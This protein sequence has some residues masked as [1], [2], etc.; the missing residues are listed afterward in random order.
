MQAF[1]F[2]LLLCGANGAGE[3][4]YLL[5]RFHHGNI[6][7]GAAIHHRSGP[8]TRRVCHCRQQPRI[9]SN[10]FGTR[11]EHAVDE[12]HMGG[13]NNDLPT[14][15][16]LTIQT[17]ISP[18]PIEVC[19]V[20]PTGNEWVC[21][22]SSS[23]FEEDFGADV[24]GFSGLFAPDIPPGAGGITA[25]AS[26]GTDGCHPRGT[27]GNLVRMIEAFGSFQRGQNF[28]LAR[29]DPCTTFTL[30]Q[31]GIQHRNVGRCFNLW[32]NNGLEAGTHDGLQIVSG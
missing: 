25:L 6:H 12:R 27:G 14:I 5:R 11:R 1:N 2:P 10:L 28:Y 7:H 4:E 15:A 16:E 24:E 18:Q 21:Q 8:L 23:G 32:G 22:A 31:E 20:E 30:R 19:D 3:G 9:I 29:R 17:H 13:V 26:R